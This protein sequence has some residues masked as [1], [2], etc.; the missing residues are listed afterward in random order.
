[1]NGLMS[2]KPTSSSK[3]SSGPCRWL[4][5]GPYGTWFYFG[6][7]LVPPDT[8]HDAI[9]DGFTPEGRLITTWGETIQ[10]TW[11]QWNAEAVGMWGIGL[12]DT[13]TDCQLDFRSG[14]LSR[15]IYHRPQCTTSSNGRRL[16][17]RIGVKGRPAG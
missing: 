7:Y 8:K 14:W 12:A 16:G 9:V 2:R 10:L 13:F 11:E 3:S 1:M 4:T 17:L 15:R 5:A 6:T